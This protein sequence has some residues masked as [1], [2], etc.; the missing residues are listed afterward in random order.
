MDDY[1]YKIDDNYSYSNSEKY[2]NEG[3]SLTSK[4]NKI[5]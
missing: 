4:L 2:Y 5:G 3:K 1:F